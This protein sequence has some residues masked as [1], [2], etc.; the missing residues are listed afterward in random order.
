MTKMR[1]GLMVIVAAVLGGSAG[2]ALA[3][4][5]PGGLPA[6]LAELHSCHAS[7]ET[8]T[9]TQNACTAESETC[10]TD[11]SG[12]TAELG[13][14]TKDLNARTAELGTCA[15]DLSGRTAE[16]GT[17]GTTLNA[18]TAELGTCTTDLNACHATLAG[19]QQLAASC[20]TDL[21]AC[22]ANLE[23]CTTELNACHTTPAPTA[24]F[25]ASGQTT[26]WNGGVPIP[27]AD[28]GQ[29]GDTRAGA[30]LSYTDNGDGT[31]TDNNTKLVWEKKS[32]D[33]G[34]HDVNA[35]YPWADAFAVHIDALNTAS[36][37]G[38]SD[39]RL[40]NVRELQSI[41]NYENFNPSVSSEFNNNCTSGAPTVLTGSCTTASQYWASSTSARAPAFGWAVIF[42][43]GLVGEF[44]KAFVFR[45]RAVRGGL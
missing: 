2:T 18:R 26:C 40:P 29:D 32:A 39:W 22:D 45:A 30:T 1:R 36:F 5:F 4:P 34:I 33:G 16:L 14:C 12:R 13:T 3:Q 19:A 41:V 17:C 6:C 15:T 21:N 31:I 8:C 11:L 35:G 42:N 28:T 10:A 9:T 24:K 25:P 20:L 27:C 44:S 23:T 37:A 7:L 38:H 43:D